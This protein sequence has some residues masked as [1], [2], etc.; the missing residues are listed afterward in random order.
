MDRAAQH[1]VALRR[2][3]AWRLRR[4]TGPS[5][6]K[7]AAKL[8]YVGHVGTGFDEKELARIAK[9][10]KARATPTLRSPRASP[11]TSGLTG[12]APSSSPRSGSR[13]GPMRSICAIRCIS[14]CGMTRSRR[15]SRREQGTAAASKSRCRPDLQVETCRREPELSVVDQL[16]A[17]EDARNDGVITLPNGDSLKVTNPAKVFWPKQ[18]IT[19]GE[20]LRYYAQVSPFLLPAVEDRPLVMKRFPNGIDGPGVLPAAIAGGEAA[21]RRANR[22]RWRR[23][24]GSDRR[25]GRAAARRRIADDAALHDPDRGDLAGP[26]V[27]AGAVAALRGS[28]RDR[29]R[30]G[31]RGDVRAGA[32][33]RALD[34]G[35]AGR[36]AA[37]RACPRHRDRAGCTS[38]SRCRR[39]P[40]TNPGSCSARSSRRSS[41]SKHPKTATVERTVRGRPRGTVL[42]G[43]PA[44][45]PRKDAGDGIQRSCQ[46]V[47]RRLDAADVEGGRRRRRPARFH[48]PDRAGAVRRG[49]R[50]VG[51]AADVGAGGSH[52][53]L[54]GN[55][56]VVRLFR[57][58]R[59]QAPYPRLR[60]RPRTPRRLPRRGR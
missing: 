16:H 6:G 38:T 27:L 57:P 35:R 18:K 44:E 15:R 31:R 41:P 43:L 26:V 21:A 1:A 30:S 28:G 10:L 13:S 55:T 49:R 51:T 52:R 59:R 36:A 3:A 54:Y 46:R 32:R 48:H 7:P 47:R 53:G 23:R 20:L 56:L 17:L 24:A 50:F 5:P 22:D 39:R 37:F 40:R 33:R 4:R 29:S 9:L 19:K 42:R 34:A 45:H 58:P 14:D 8:T 11:R 12:S 60:P 2:A 25:A